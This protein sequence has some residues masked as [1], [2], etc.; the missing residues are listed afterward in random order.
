MSVNKTNPSAIDF[1]ERAHVPPKVLR[2]AKQAQRDKRK[3]INLVKAREDP[4]NYS[5]ELGTCWMCWLDL[6]G[7]ET[8]EKWRMEPFSE[9]KLHEKVCPLCGYPHWK[10]RVWYPFRYLRG[11][12]GNPSSRYGMKDK[13]KWLK[14]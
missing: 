11:Y 7:E 5:V 1:G 12:L 13:V 2:E 9:V 14:R 3:M 10:G 6:T 4:D 8:L